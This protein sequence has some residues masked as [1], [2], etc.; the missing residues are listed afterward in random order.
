MSELELVRELFPDRVPD[1]VAR[2]RVRAAVAARTFDRRRPT[3]RSLRPVSTPA[4]QTALAP[5]P[6]AS[7]APL[8]RSQVIIRISVGE[9]T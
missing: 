7:V 6:Q 2:E 3:L 1:D 9:I 4:T 5:V 8:P